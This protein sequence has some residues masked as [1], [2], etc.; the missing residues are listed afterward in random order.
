MYCIFYLIFARITALRV[1]LKPFPESAQPTLY[2]SCAQEPVYTYG[3]TFRFSSSGVQRGDQTS[4]S[5]QHRYNKCCDSTVCVHV[6]YPSLQVRK[7]KTKYKSRH[8]IHGRLLLIR[9]RLRGSIPFYNTKRYAGK[10]MANYLSY[11]M[12][13]YHPHSEDPRRP[14]IGAFD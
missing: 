4:S 2:L 13:I 7:K 12:N 8:K 11:S 9:L 6:S 14:F 3:L 10:L 5:Q 1:E